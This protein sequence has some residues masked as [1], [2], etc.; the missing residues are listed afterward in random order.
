VK[1][2][3]FERL[4]TGSVKLNAQE[5]R[6]CVYR[7]PFNELLRNLANDQNFRSCLGSSRV[8]DRMQDAELILRFLAFYDRSFLNYNSPMKSFLN[9][10][11][12]ENRNIGAEKTE[13]LTKAFK[14]ATEL[15]HTV[16]GSNA[17][18][19][20]SYGS[21]KSTSG[22]WEKAVNRALF[23]VVMWGFTQ[24]EKR[25]IVPCADT[26]RDEFI[27][28]CNDDAEFKDAITQGTG[29][30]SRT[31]YRFEAWRARLKT[32]VGSPA[33]E[34]RSFEAQMRQSMFKSDPRCKI[35]GQ[36]IRS[37]DDCEVDHIMPYSKGGATDQSNAQLAH[38]HCNRSK[39]NQH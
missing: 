9:G 21:S 33:S 30:K 17:F 10:Y 15:S 11:M 22:D 16:F 13:K 19:K 29:D 8:L 23:D 1:F 14:H 7:G 26:I 25:Q 5:L 6:N 24:Y 18:R 20:F 35:C 28:L 38:R 39:S 32:V 36:M 27:L 31:L 34:Q 4:N 3:I 2:E 12:N 37:M